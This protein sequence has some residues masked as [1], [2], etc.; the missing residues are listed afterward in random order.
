MSATD[1]TRQCWDCLGY[2]AHVAGH[3][4]VNCATCAGTGRQWLSPVDRMAADRDR[5]K[6]V[7]DAFMAGD[8]ERAAALYNR[9]ADMHEGGAR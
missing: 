5:W 2:G 6:A 8:L 7:A 9:T 1:N 3:V 4:R